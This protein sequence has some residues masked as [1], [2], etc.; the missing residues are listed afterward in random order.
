MK[1]HNDQI[2]N[3]KTHDWTSIGQDFI[4]KNCKAAAIIEYTGYGIN[5]TGFHSIFIYTNTDKYFP[6]TCFYRKTY[7]SCNEIVLMSILC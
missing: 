4:C 5:T 6:Q 7:L 1:F 3:G 2:E